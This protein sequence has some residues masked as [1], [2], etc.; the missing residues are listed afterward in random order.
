MRLLLIL[1]LSC[2]IWSLEAQE[3]SELYKGL[4]FRNIGPSRGGRSVAS[5]GVIGDPMTY[6]MGSTGGGLWKTTDAGVSWKNISDK[7]FKMGS[8]GAVEVA[9]SD[10]Y[11]V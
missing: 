5:C 7:F 10:P 3:L 11:E 9:P 2:C 4:K 6:Y 1:T 8:V